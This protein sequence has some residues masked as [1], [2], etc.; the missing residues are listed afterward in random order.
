MH[1][2]AIVPDRTMTPYDYF[3][4]LTVTFI[5]ALLIAQS[6]LA[7]QANFSWTP[8]DASSGTVG[9]KIYYGTSS[10]M[11]TE[12][13]DVGSPVPVYGSMHASVFQ[14][15]PGQ[16]YFFAVVAYNADGYESSYSSEI[17]Y[18]VPSDTVNSSPYDLLVS[19]SPSLSSAVA[20]DGATVEG[21]IYVFTGPDAGVA[22]VTFSVD[23]VVVQRES[24]APYEL[25]GG[26]A[27][28]TSQMSSGTHEIT[29][30]ILLKD[31]RTQLARAIFTIPNVN[32]SLLVPPQNVNDSLYD[33]LVSISPSLSSAVALDGAVVEG[34]IYV[35][36]GPDAG[37]A[38][39]TFS[40]DGV[41]A[42]AESHAPFELVGGNAFDTSQMSSGTHEITANILLKDGRSQLVR[43]VF[44]IPKVND[45]LYNILVS[46][47]SSLSSAIPLDG[48]TV[49]GDIYVFTGPDA[50]VARVTFFIDG[51]LAQ[52]ES[53]APFELLGGAAFDTSQMS[54]GSHEIIAN[55]LLSDGSSEQIVAEF[56]IP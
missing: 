45:S 30:N 9:Y 37:V 12:F 19:E 11:Y 14:L 42:Q 55:I 8:N 43:A 23:G 53:H 1:N 47:S 35:F 36:T 39:V 18:T 31:G 49:G 41:V 52:S 4:V 22:G 40:I 32:D 33:L 44:T 48:T 38:R 13:V 54:P 17:A 2:F 26:S 34:D 51:A 28:D 27:F 25:V 24:A 56:M 7:A 3:K 10:R 50:G 29:A 5:F 46:E 15:A 20:L 16:K 21:D 6:A